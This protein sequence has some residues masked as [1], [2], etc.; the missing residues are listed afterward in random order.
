MVNAERDYRMDDDEGPHLTID[1]DLES[2]AKDPE[3]TAEKL[4][5]SF[6]KELRRHN[7]SDDQI[8][9]VATELIGCLSHSLEGYRKKVQT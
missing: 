8:I 4:A 1:V 9:R 5:R 2:A 3:R 7:F 6:Y